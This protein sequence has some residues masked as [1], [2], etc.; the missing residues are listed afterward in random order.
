MQGATH[1]D[2]HAVEELIRKSVPSHLLF[3]DLDQLRAL[4]ETEPWVR[5]AVVRRRLPGDLF[6]YIGERQPAAVAAIDGDLYVVGREGAILERFGPRHQGLDGPIVKGLKSVARENAEEE[7]MLR[8]GMY[9]RVLEELKDGD[10]DYS[11]TVSEIDVED[12]GRVGVIPSDEPVPVYLGDGDFLKRYQI[13]LSRKD[14]YLQLKERHGTITSVDVTFENRIIFHT[15]DGQ[16]GAGLDGKR[17]GR[18]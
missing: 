9:L 17:G 18:S 2:P 16:M 5:S 12:P 1:A 13:F 3:A 8:M 11:Q 14:L 4:V 7:N 6:I 10:R 15:G